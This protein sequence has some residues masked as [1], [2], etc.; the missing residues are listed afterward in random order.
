ME[1]LLFLIFLVLLF[2]VVTFLG[3][4]PIVGWGAV[5]LIVLGLIGGL[6]SWIGEVADRRSY[7]QMLWIGDLRRT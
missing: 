5:I 3:A 1:I 2:G 7:C 4:W 6:L